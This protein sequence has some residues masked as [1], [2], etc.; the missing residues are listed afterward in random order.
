M[1]VQVYAVEA[2][3]TLN[4]IGSLASRLELPAGILDKF[5]ISWAL[6]R[7]TFDHAA[8]ITSNFHYHGIELAGS[9][10]ALLRPMNEALKRGTW[11]AFCATAAETADFIAYDRI[12][13]RN[14]ALEIEKHPP[15]DRFPIF[16]QQYQN[17]WERFHSFT[18]GGN[19][20]VG[21]YTMGHG[22]GPAFPEKDVF[23]VLDHAEGIAVT[24]VHVMCMIAGEFVPDI[25]KE[26]LAAL[27]KSQQREIGWPKTERSSPGTNGD[28]TCKFLSPTRDLPYV[29]SGQTKLSLQP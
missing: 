3:A 5:R 18:H 23:L 16:T 15:F 22:I 14:I 28:Q 2:A 20:V 1:T 21:A 8:S 7:L 25:A 6:L 29:V 12:P 11:F 24:A 27:K 19:Q 17:A 26:T 13:K 4:Y 9:P 10:F